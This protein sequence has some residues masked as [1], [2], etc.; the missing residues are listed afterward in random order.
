MGM[1]CVFIFVLPTTELTAKRQRFNGV[2]L[3]KSALRLSSLWGSFSPGTLET[4]FVS[5]GLVPRSA[6]SSEERR[7]R[8]PLVF[9][10]SYWPLN[11]IS[12][13]T[14]WLPSTGDQP[15]IKN[16]GLLPEAAAMVTVG[17][18]SIGVPS[19]VP[20]GKAKSPSAQ[21]KKSFTHRSVSDGS[22]LTG[23]TCNC[24]AS[25]H[26]TSYEAVSVTITNT[27]GSV[28]KE[29][30]TPLT[31]RIFLRERAQNRDQL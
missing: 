24:S 21:M 14:F 13:C 15:S 6:S 12:H 5:S 19:T 31:Q 9:S 8:L 1:C 17:M 4:K 27:E 28:Q 2:A 30:T 11:A 16:F 18:P 29:S 7:G 25:R 22:A 23:E 20:S 26:L 10:T 3:Y